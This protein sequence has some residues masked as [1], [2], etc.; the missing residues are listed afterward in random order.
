[1]TQ[2]ILSRPSENTFW[3]QYRKGLITTFRQMSRAEQESF[4][5]KNSIAVTMGAAVV[6]VNVVYAVIPPVLRVFGIPLV[7]LGSF[8][9]GKTVVTSRVIER[10]QRHLNSPTATESDSVR[11]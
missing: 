3:T 10:F 9:L 2:D 11:Q 1:M 7:I 8:L 4:I 6:M 5:R